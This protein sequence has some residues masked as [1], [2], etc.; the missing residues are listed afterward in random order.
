MSAWSAG[1]LWCKQS[2]LLMKLVK[3]KQGRAV[4]QGDLQRLGSQKQLG[5]KALVQPALYTRLPLSE[6]GWSDWTVL[7]R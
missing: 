1:W 5:L 4:P 3:D 7:S 2:A 6:Y